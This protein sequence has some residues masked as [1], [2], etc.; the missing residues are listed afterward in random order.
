MTRQK[1]NPAD[2]WYLREFDFLPE[3]LAYYGKHLSKDAQNEIL[4]QERWRLFRSKEEAQKACNRVRTALGLNPYP[5][6]W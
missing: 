5:F 4:S 6:I 2:W 3:N 1:F